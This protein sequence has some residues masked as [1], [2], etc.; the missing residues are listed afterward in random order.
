MGVPVQGEG[1][2]GGGGG[3]AGE[4][5]ASSDTGGVKAM[6]IA[7]RLVNERE[8]LAGMSD[9][10]R[11]FRRQ[12]LHDQHLAPSEPRFVPEYHRER[13]NPIRRFYKW[14]LDTLATKMHPVV[15]NKIHYIRYFTGKIAM[16]GFTVLGI[17]YYFKYR[18][19]DWINKSG[20]RVS[21]SRPRILEGEPGYEERKLKKPSEY[22]VR[23]F[24]KSPI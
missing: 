14:P 8:R 22:L 16:F 1:G 17:H 5:L 12:W 4:K 7:S 6:N 11:A 10:E 2:G 15:G 24:E 19:N 23:G 20:W 3:G 13:F 21:M 18:G 9:E